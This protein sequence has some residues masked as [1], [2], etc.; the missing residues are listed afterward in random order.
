VPLLIAYHRREMASA[1]A[2]SPLVSLVLVAHDMEREL[3]R[4][5]LSL[6]PEMQRGIEPEAYELIVVDNGSR[7]PLDAAAFERFGMRVQVIRIDDAPASPAA[8]LNV[9]LGAA[10][11]PL[12]G[13]MID[14]A[15]LCSP[16][17]LRLA[18]LGSRVHARAVV[19]TLSFHLGPDVQPRSIAAGY[20]AGR[21]DRLLEEAR[22]TEDGYRLFDI[23]VFAVSSAGGWFAP[24]AESNALFMSDRLWKELGGLDERF[25]APGGGFV[26]LD[27]YERACALPDSQLVILLGEATF[28]QVHGGVATNSTVPP[29]EFHDEYVRLRGRPFV[30]PVPDPF[31]VGAPSGPALRSIA[32]SAA[33]VAKQPE[34]SSTPARAQSDSA[35]R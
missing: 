9:G 30:R 31:Y 16:G 23:S 5:V 14:G 28:H 7:H 24:L 29:T 32:A 12:V 1:L 27:L 20:D 10:C 3:P 15:R 11:A 6:S 33:E 34:H 13:A 21:E 2:P 19:A 26:N 18:L 22:W 17:L 25:E 8:G 4:T 35:V